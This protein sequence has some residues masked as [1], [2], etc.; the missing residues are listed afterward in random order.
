MSWFSC[1]YK[2][3]WGFSKHGKCSGRHRKGYRER[4]S[5]S[6]SQLRTWREDLQRSS[7]LH[8]GMTHSHPL[9]VPFVALLFVVL[10]FGKQNEFILRLQLSCS[11]PMIKSILR[12]IIHWPDWSYCCLIC[13]AH[14]FQAWKERVDVW[15]LGRNILFGTHSNCFLRTAPPSGRPTFPQRSPLLSRASRVQKICEALRKE[16]FFLHETRLGK[17]SQFYRTESMTFFF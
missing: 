4:N 12:N 16:A 6:C 3:K 11:I 8:Y 14:I 10:K 13:S 9:W 5:P 1:L 7:Q 15:N 2:S 17:R